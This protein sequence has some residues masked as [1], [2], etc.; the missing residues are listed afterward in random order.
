MLIAFEH[1]LAFFLLKI[2]Q[3]KRSYG[4]TVVSLHLG[5]ATYSVPI[6]ISLDEVSDFID[7]IRNANSTKV[8]LLAPLQ[9]FL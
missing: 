2:P 6:F 4:H 8:N 9:G 5:R 3:A 7:T 1:L